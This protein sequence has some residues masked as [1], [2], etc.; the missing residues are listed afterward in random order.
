MSIPAQN[1][2]GD[3]PAIVMLWDY[4]PA[5][6]ADYSTR[7]PEIAT[8]SY[9]RQ[10]AALLDDRYGWPGD[11]SRYL[12]RAG[13]PTRFIVGNA[14]SAQRA[15]AEENG[16]PVS[17]H[18]VCGPGVVLEQLRRFRPRVLW[19]GVLFSYHGEF[20]REAKQYC[21]RIVA[22][23]GAPFQT[24]VDVE[25]VS[26]LLT[27]NPDTLRTARDR[28]ER[29]IVTKPGFDATIVDDLGSVE[30]QYDVSFVGGITRLHQRRASSLACLLRHGVGLTVHS[31][32]YDEPALG[33]MEG[34]RIAAWDLFRKKDARGCIDDLRRTW[35]PTAYERDLAL[36]GHVRRPPVF[37]LQMYRA[38]AASRMTV[39]VH[40]DVSGKHSGNMRM[41]EATGVGCCLVTE[42]AE[43]MA[44]LF[45]A[46]RE[47]VTYRTKS[48]LLEKVRWLLSHPAETEKIGK[49]GKAR[50]HRC[51]TLE[52]MWNDIEPLFDL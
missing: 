2:E 3:R 9:D 4:D 30:K 14:L 15:W 18:A 29:I 39:N 51:H 37:G 47:V 31:A 52:R 46:G 41:F 8:A 20:L 7:C 33:K 48:E 45:E 42:E 26:A 50:T 21:D 32:M 6:L 5:Y 38:L 36:L 23:M 44:Q 24:Q 25:G 19:V 16:V 40:I 17:E 10:M 12:C 13:I 22:W 11:L 28:F 1:K 49:S 35:I 34:C 43:N 27:E